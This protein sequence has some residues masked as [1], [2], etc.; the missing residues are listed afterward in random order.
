M[1]RETNETNDP[2][3]AVSENVVDTEENLEL[4]ENADAG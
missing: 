2:Y 1:S 3:A 4:V